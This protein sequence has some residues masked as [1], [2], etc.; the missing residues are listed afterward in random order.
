[1]WPSVE[2]YFQAQR[3]AVKAHRERIRKADFILAPGLARDREQKLRPDWEPIK[4]SVLRAAMLA[5][6]TQDDELRD[7]LLSTDAA[8]LVDRTDYSPWGDSGDGGE[9]NLFGRILMEVREALRAV[10]D[11]A[12]GAAPDPARDIGSGSS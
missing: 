9:E 5:K 10:P 4:A 6:F 2:H 11:A 12:P 1:M 3:F 7:L 8:E